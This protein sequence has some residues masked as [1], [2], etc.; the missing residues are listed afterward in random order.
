M[1]HPLRHATT[2]GCIPGRFMTELV[3]R[4]RQVVCKYRDAKKGFHQV[5]VD[6]D[7]AY[8]ATNWQELDDK[9]RMKGIAT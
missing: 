6:L 5:I 2:I 4:L 7:K 9:M 8:Y 1:D 3:I